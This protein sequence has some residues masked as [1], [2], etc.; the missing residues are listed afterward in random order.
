MFSGQHKRAVITLLIVVFFA[1]GFWFSLGVQRAFA[2][3]PVIDVASLKVL[4]KQFITESRK[5][6]WKKAGIVA[7]DRAITSFV[8]RMAQQ[9]G[10]FLATGGKGRTSLQRR[11][12][13][14]SIIKKSGEAAV[15]DFVQD[16]SELSGLNEL[17]LNLCNPSAQLKANIS[18]QLLGEVKPL[19]PSRCDI[20]QIQENWRRVVNRDNF[21]A[22][23][24]FGTAFRVSG[25][26]TGPGGRFGVCQNSTGS[27]GLPDQQ[28]KTGICQAAASQAGGTSVSQITYCNSDSECNGS[29]GEV[30]VFVSPSSCTD[31]SQC[32]AG[33]VCNFGSGDQCLK[34]SDCD[35]G[36]RCIGAQLSSNL[37]WLDLTRGESV[38]QKLEKFNSW[39]S[40]QQN[41][42]GAYIAITQQV[43]E[44]EAA[45]K[46]YASLNA[47]SCKGYKDLPVSSVTDQY[48]RRTCDEIERLNQQSGAQSATA[49]DVTGSVFSAGDS[50]FWL[51]AAKVF[52]QSLLAGLLKKYIRGGS[53]SLSQVDRG[54]DI[55][56][57]RQN[58][59][60]RL[61]EGST[62][63]S[64][65]SSEQV[66]NNLASLQRPP[67]ASVNNFDYLSAFTVCPENRNNV[68]LDNCSI[69]DNFASAIREKKTVAE[70]IAEGSLNPNAPLVSNLNISL[71]SD[72][73]CIRSGYCHSNIVRLRKYR[74]VPI[75]WEIAASL[76]PIDKPITLGE[77]V[78]CFENGSRCTLDAESNIFYH[79]IDPNWVLK[80]PET[81]C[82]ALAYG[83]K[84][85]DIE[86][87]ERQQY[88]ADSISCLAEDDEGNCIGGFGYCTKEKGVWR[89]AGNQCPMQFSS[90]N[91]YSRASDG[92]SFAYLGNTLDTCDASQ[93][94]CLWY[95]KSQENVGTESN[96][97]LAWNSRDRIYFNNQVQKCDATQ[98]G[99]SQFV[100]RSSAGGNLLAHGDFDYFT[101]NPATNLSDPNW[102]N[103]A[104]PDSFDGW[105]GSAQ[106]LT[107]SD[108]AYYGTVGVHLKGS[109]RFSAQSLTGILSDKTFILSWVGKSNTTDPAGC[110]SDV[111]IASQSTPSQSTEVVYTSDWKRY[112]LST[113][114]DAQNLDT[115][116]L[117]SFA[118]ECANVSAGGTS[119][120]MID[121]VKLETGDRGTGFSKY[122]DNGYVYLKSQFQCTKED[123]GCDKYTP[124]LGGAAIPG[125]IDSRDLC[126]SE[127]VGYQNYLELV[128]KFDVLE[129]LTTPPPPPPVP[130]SVNFIA[131]TANACSPTQVDCEEFTNLDEVAKGGEGRYYFNYVRQCVEDSLGVTYYTLEGSDTAGYQVRTWRL[132]QSNLGDQPCT[133]VDIGAKTCA[134]DAINT[135]ATTCSAADLQTNL[136]CRE[137]FD[138]S[139]NPHYVLQNRVIFASNDCQPYRRSATG[140]TFYALKNESRQCE[141]K[142]NGCREYRGNQGNNLRVIFSDAFETGGIR[143]WD[144]NLSTLSSES[145]TTG[146]HAIANVNT[147]NV[148]QSTMSRVGALPIGIGRE[149][150]FEFW[151]KNEAPARITITLTSPP[152]PP[153]SFN[154]L[155]VPVKSNWQLYRLGPVYVNTAITAQPLVTIA[156]P[157]GGPVPK[158]FLD[159]IVLKESVSNLYVIKNSWKTPASCD[160][161]VPGAMLG[162]QTYTNA[163]GASYNLRSFARLCSEDVIGCQAFIDTRNS[164]NPFQKIYNQGDP[165]QVTVL[166]DNLTYLVYKQENLCFAESKG[167]SAL[168]EPQLNVDLPEEHPRYISGYAIATLTNDPDTYDT[169]LCTDSGLFCEEYSTSRG[170][171]IFFKNPRG[172]TCAYKENVNIEGGLYTGWFQTKSLEAGTVPK[173][174]SD[175]GVLPYD[176]ADFRLIK[177][178]E[179]SYDRWVGQCS[180]PYDR[181]TEF[182]DPTDTQGDNALANADFGQSEASWTA[183]A[184]N[185]NILT[186]TPGNGPTELFDT[187]PALRYAATRVD[188]AGSTAVSQTFTPSDPAGIY[189]FG[190]D[191]NL[192]GLVQASSVGV[193]CTWDAVS[194]KDYCWNPTPGSYDYTKTCLQD[195]DCGGA[196]LICKRYSEAYCDNQNTGEQTS[197]PCVTDANCVSKLGAGHVCRIQSDSGLNTGRDHTAL[198]RVQGD[199]NTRTGWQTI[200]GLADLGSDGNRQQLLSCDFDMTQG[201]PISSTVKL[202]GLWAFDETSGLIAKDTSGYNNDASLVPAASPPTWQS[203]KINGAL[204][205][206]DNDDMVT[207]PHNTI[208]NFGTGPFSMSLWVKTT[209]TTGVLASKDP[210]PSRG[211]YLI[212]NGLVKFSVYD[213]GQGGEDRVISTKSVNDGQFHHIVGVRDATRMLLYIDGVLNNS[214]P[215]QG[216]KTVNYSPPG[217]E[218]PIK[219]SSDDSDISTRFSGVMDELALYQGVLSAT[220]IKLLASGISSGS[221]EILWQN[222]IFKQAKGYYY[223]DDDEI[224]NKSCAGQAGKRDGCLLFLDT[225]DRGAKRYNA[226]RTYEL[227]R[228][229]NGGL[230]AP[231]VC[232]PSDTT[233]L[234]DSNRIIKVTRDRQCTEWLAC[235]SATEVFDPSTNTFRQ[236]CDQIGTC[237]QYVSGS[238]ILSCGNWVQP[239]RQRLEYGIYTNRN[240]DVNAVDYT[241]YSMYNSYEVGTLELVD[242]SNNKQ[243]P[244]GPDGRNPDYR[245]VRVIDRCDSTNAYE[246]GCGP[247][248]PLN[249][250]E[251]MGRCFAPNKCVVGVDGSRFS[252]DSDYIVRLSTRAWAEKDS[253][254]PYS[255]VESDTGET[256]K[257]KFGFQESNICDSRIASCE[258]RYY[259]FQYGATGGSITRYFAGDLRLDSGA[260][261]ACVCQGG[262]QDGQECLTSDL[263]NDRKLS[264]DERCPD[265]GA[266]LY[267]RR[268]ESFINLPGYCLE[269]DNRA[270]INGSQ[271]ERAC[272]TW[273]PVE[274]APTGF[275]F[276]N[277]NREAGYSYKIPAYYCLEVG[278][279]ELR[280]TH[281]LDCRCST[282]NAPNPGDSD[283]VVYRGGRCGDC[284][285]GFHKKYKYYEAPKGEG[286][287]CSSNFFGITV[288]RP[289]AG[290][291]GLYP[292][293]GDT[294]VCPDCDEAYQ[295]TRPD[296][297][298]QVIAQAVDERGENAAKTN[299]FWPGYPLGTG[300]GYFVGGAG[301][302]VN[303]FSPGSQGYGLKQDE[304]PFGSA[305]PSGLGV[306]TEKLEIRDPR[307]VP[308][309]GSPYACS[310]NAQSCSLFD[311]SSGTDAAVT[312]WKNPPYKGGET[313]V[314]G[315]KRLKEIYKKIFNLYQWGRGD[316]CTDFVCGRTDD[317]GPA[318]EGGTQFSSYFGGQICDPGDF[319][320]CNSIVDITACT[321][322]DHKCVNSVFNSN[323]PASPLY[324]VCASCDPAFH[325]EQRTTKKCESNKTFSDINGNGSP[326]D[327]CAST[328]LD[329]NVAGNQFCS[330][331]K[332]A[333]GSS[334]GC[335]LDPSDATKARCYSTNYAGNDCKIPANPDGSL[336]ASNLVCQLNQATNQSTCRYAGADTFVPC[337]SNADCAANDDGNEETAAGALSEINKTAYCADN[338][339]EGPYDYGT[340]QF[341]VGQPFTT[342]DGYVFDSPPVHCEPGV[343]YTNALGYQLSGSDICTNLGQCLPSYR[344]KYAQPPLNTGK[345]MCTREPEGYLPICIKTPTNDCAGIPDDRVIDSASVPAGLLPLDETRQEEPTFSPYLIAAVCDNTGINC[346]QLKPI[347]QFR[348]PTDNGFSVNNILGTDPNPAKNTVVGFQNLQVSLRFYMAADKNHMPIRY[349]E[350]EWGDGLKQ[351][352]VGY[353]KNHLEQCGDPTLTG[354][355]T[356]SQS[357]LEYAAAEQACR[358]STKNYLHVYAYDVNYACRTCSNDAS[359][360]CGRNEDCGSGNTCSGPPKLGSE[361]AACYRPWVMLQDNWGWCTNNEYGETGLG[362]KDSGNKA[363]VKFPGLIKVYKDPKP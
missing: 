161:P 87:S 147:S 113:S 325:S 339:I 1:V 80:A 162:C 228:A 22:N 26:V 60:Q 173:G 199:S 214:T 264:S 156:D 234:N 308:R 129:T 348:V 24:S 103:D 312:G 198:Y 218:F 261:P 289:N 107:T 287:T 150:Y 9:T 97:V 31:T 140:T 10:E 143:P 200:A 85:I 13:F 232:D 253:P 278:L 189:A 16:L 360:E 136:D 196:P 220:H 73:F 263:D 38:Q 354:P 330:G 119:E 262:K 266:P 176:A 17:G 70:A 353:Y 337:T 285:G 297:S 296:A 291:D 148:V 300:R 45:K 205:F 5:E 27:C 118:G 41:D 274:N 20:R 211:L 271:D 221:G 64:T 145:V 91:V 51:N 252:R 245:L 206:V 165:S 227:S 362:C 335:A 159:N 231:V 246:Q 286:Q 58:I 4:L 329:D 313:Y 186:N 29:A 102:L 192:R 19:P 52:G 30:C 315:V 117:I 229:N 83:P 242:V 23:I 63:P 233:C 34:D 292:Y 355:K 101:Q 209:D 193:S 122:G 106:A 363:Y 347:D 141:P 116:L 250:Q 183:I 44:L 327:E 123:V 132:L 237:N 238:D 269:G 53:F 311:Q 142:F 235:R 152:S 258:S 302:S 259:K 350:L 109:G 114:F 201:P 76:S 356:A 219:L 40:P 75:G 359:R 236:L 48:V 78:D 104:L 324:S 62:S 226:P 273:L 65:F 299:L 135:V 160:E 333:D 37:P 172:R 158:V 323:D 284:Q 18:L 254:F 15:G 170:T 146:G 59:I 334:Y 188:P 128:S 86:T 56:A 281:L 50:A 47:E 272:L 133:N 28:G 344:V 260:I 184:G 256:R 77:A 166:A 149:A 115:S 96:P 280:Y 105:Q 332:N 154:P 204:E 255:V 239:S 321:P 248:D 293:D 137:F 223:I 190:A 14:G 8:N 265:N 33:A 185:G 277:Q 361:T 126:P 244:P 320:S 257:V 12:S 345:F 121:G 306:I 342:G 241:G 197:V 213:S 247:A 191:V 301:S 131:S 42:L 314:D 68:E 215:R 74:I 84:L 340:G 303:V 341:C 93:N 110:K 79:L 181:C 310:S 167:C 217:V 69:D 61:R 72:P 112:E 202:V 346:K 32:P 251:R 194:E 210:D 195:A 328:D 155:D 225:N 144:S 326:L 46:K 67:L 130:Q 309:A 212:L 270:N 336:V 249:P 138:L 207:I 6:I 295:E 275:D 318:N 98:V 11:E 343:K 120:T 163:T 243:T 2:T 55:Q 351:S 288:C 316:A 279:Y 216:N 94:G 111:A 298:C 331:Y 90:C 177:N 208:Y 267:L 283:Y 305:V 21:T 39:F 88:C 54:T 240:L 3:Y 268:A 100:S 43:R 108:N 179:A 127:C 358:A 169:T 164:S 174:C 81:Q 224:D 187:Y 222:P 25:G 203:G 168:G 35:S 157:A 66:S 317:P 57:I 304:T 357:Q 124:V 125:R 95:S 230:V 352:R 307:V 290:P 182:K 71:N 282:K 89:F 82:R 151:M 36:Q 134:D 322:I 171:N 276:Y 180:A 49:Q 319:N 178:L 153:A 7:L 294:Y 139:G 349:V 338:V 99:C 175:D 92:A